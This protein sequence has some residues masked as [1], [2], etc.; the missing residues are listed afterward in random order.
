MNKLSAVVTG[1]VM[2]GALL[3]SGP[4]EA[5]DLVQFDDLGSGAELR[6]DLLD[7]QNTG[8]KSPEAKCGEGKCGE[9]SKASEHKCGEGKCGE[10]K[11]AAESKGTKA[12]K[13]TKESEAAA[14]SKPSEHKC[15]E[16]K[17]GESGKI[18]KEQMD[19]STK[20]PN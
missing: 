17:C 4:A 11:P 19:K 10:S 5:S 2:T 16:G 6:A 12:A 20:D 1:T 18:Q 15:G 9:E 14:E 3:S 8:F 7:A 13:E